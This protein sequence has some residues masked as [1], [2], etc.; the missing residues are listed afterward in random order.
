VRHY[1]TERPHR[2]RGIGNNVLHVDFRPARDGPIRRRRQLGGINT[3][4]TRDAA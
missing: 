4:Y 1:N 2:E 3:S